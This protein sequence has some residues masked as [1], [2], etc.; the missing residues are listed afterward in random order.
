MKHTIALLAVL[1]LTP[2]VAM[3]AGAGDSLQL[4]LALQP[5]QVIVSPQPQHIPPTK[6]QGVP[7]IERTANGRLWAIY[8]RNVESTRTYQVL[9]TSADDGRS[10]S[11]VKLMIL[12]HEGT[13]AMSANVW[14]DPL[15][16]LWLFW[17]QSANT[18]DGRFGVWAIVADDPEAAEPKWS[19]PRRLGD[20]IL[21][22]TPTVL[23][24]GDWLLPASVWKA[25]NSCRVLASADQGKTF[26]LR[27][28]PHVADPNA[29]N[30]LKNQDRPWTEDDRRVADEVSSY[31]VNFVKTGN[32]NG[33]NLPRWQPFDAGNPSTMTLAAKSGPRPIAEQE[34]LAFYRDL[35]EKT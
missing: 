1:L 11:A 8:G 5:A 31:W 28:T 26:Q 2:L 24:N 33:G 32:P 19:A 16:R 30:D 34:R 14:I 4:D 22:N 23:K 13:R 25:D 12:P 10:W 15:G 27:G 17:G 6:R 21:L 3:Q 9:K 35:L 18:Q 7:G 29:F 20:G